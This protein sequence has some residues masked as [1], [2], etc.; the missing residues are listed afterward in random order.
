MTSNG[1][2]KGNRSWPQFQTSGMDLSVGS[3]NA[4]L[5]A[6][7][8]VNGLSTTSQNRLGSNRQIGEIASKVVDLLW[9]NAAEGRG[10]PP[11]V[12]TYNAYLK[13]V[14]GPTTQRIAQR[15]H[16]FLDNMCKGT[17]RH[18]RVLPKP[19]TETF[20]TVIQLWSCV[21]GEKAQKKISELRT[22]LKDTQEE[23]PELVPNRETYLSILASTTLNSTIETEAVSTYFDPDGAREL[24]SEM[25]QAYIRTRDESLRPDTEVYNAALRWCGGPNQSSYAPTIPWDKYNIIFHDGFRDNNEETDALIDEAKL[26]EEWLNQMESPD[27]QTYESVIQ[28][29]VRTGTLEGVTNAETWALRLLENPLVES[30]QP[31]LQTFHPIIAAWAYSGDK[32]G[33]K[34]VEEWKDRLAQQSST[35]PGIQ[36]DGRVESALVTAWR[37]QQEKL[38]KQHREEDSMSHSSHTL[39]PKLSETARTCASSLERICEASCQPK[40]AEGPLNLFI[41]G[42]LFSEVV[43]AWASIIRHCQTV[44]GNT[45]GAEEASEEAL[46]KVFLVAKLLDDTIH[47]FRSM[48]IDEKKSYLDEE[49]DTEDLNCEVDFLK[50]WRS[51]QLRHLIYSASD[52]Y[53]KCVAIFT[54]VDS[55]L[56]KA[57]QSNSLKTYDAPGQNAFS[58]F[59]FEIESMLRRSEEYGKFL[60]QCDPTD[61]FEVVYEDL[62]S[63]SASL[64]STEN[65]S[66]HER[67]LLYREVITGCTNLTS[68][69]H[70]GDAVR[71]CMFILEA[72]KHSIHEFEGYER[73]IVNLYSDVVS[74]LG[75]KIFLKPKERVMVLN[76]VSDHMNSVDEALAANQ[77]STNGVLDL[78]PIMKKIQETLEHTAATEVDDHLKNRYSLTGSIRGDSSNLR[79]GGKKRRTKPRQRRRRKKAT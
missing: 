43:D 19:N 35:T 39:L 30:V 28:S 59:L 20:N 44:D 25:N 10:D 7:A 55:T 31:R 40:E 12:Q 3:G 15:A 67:I 2:K 65:Q 17:K 34:K 53:T 69:S 66:S 76:F 77:G 74:V 79:A 13:C 45:V 27:I 46:T 32:R 62:F 26:V 6:L 51:R 9:K 33:P 72:L 61:D 11:N 42:H 5:T 16:A 54:E 70:V 4:I 49:L 37:N 71:L 24:I 63:Y 73:D 75:N 23:I 78:K 18:D 14:G 38:L 8:N 56:T 29:W 57:N 36:P 47:Y 21:G 48:E 41:E 52:V 58:R 68:L 60:N 22:L 50:D 64:P 1:E